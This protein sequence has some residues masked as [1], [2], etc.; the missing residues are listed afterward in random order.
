M[1]R[2]PFP[3]QPLAA[4]VPP[5]GVKM[6][7]PTP[8]PEN[9]EFVVLTLTGCPLVP[10]K[11]SSPMAPT[12]LIAACAVL[13]IE[14]L[15]VYATCPAEYDGGT[16]KK[17]ELL[18]ASPFGVDTLMRPELVFEGTLMEIALGVAETVGV[19]LVFSNTRLFGAVASKLIPV[20]VISVEAGAVVGVKVVMAGWPL[21]AVTVNVPDEV[22]DPEG[23]V[24]LIVPL[25]AADGTVAIS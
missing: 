23:D 24:T 19:E 4:N 20:I 15:P 21:S 7:M 16:T 11:S 17:S 6:E 14:V 8:Q 2:N 22:A 5:V 12:V 10:S 1:P 3:I 25:V 18:T 13:P 9:V